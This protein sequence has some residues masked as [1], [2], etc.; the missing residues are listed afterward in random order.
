MGAKKARNCHLTIG[1]PWPKL[2]PDQPCKSIPQHPPTC[3]PA[4]R[5]PYTQPS[6][7]TPTN[8][9]PSLQSLEESL[10]Y[11]LTITQTKRNQRERY[12]NRNAGLPWRQAWMQSHLA[13]GLL[14]P[15]GGG[16]TTSNHLDLEALGSQQILPKFSPFVSRIISSRFFWSNMLL[17][18]NNEC[19]FES[20]K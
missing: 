5:Q 16:Q 18:Y 15:F 20:Y 4:L 12:I 8:C 9:Y 7:P 2:M 6:I 11:I 17:F 14:P 10:G 13:Q 3:P 1:L 19:I